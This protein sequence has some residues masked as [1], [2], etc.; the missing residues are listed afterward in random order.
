MKGGLRQSIF[1]PGRFICSNKGCRASAVQPGFFFFPFCAIRLSRRLAV[2][3]GLFTPSLGI[4]R[5]PAHTIAFRIDHGILAG[6]YHLPHWENSPEGLYQCLEATFAHTPP[7]AILVE[8]PS[9]YFAVQHFL[10]RRQMLVPE[11]VSLVCLS[12]HPA[13]E[14]CRPEVTHLNWGTAGL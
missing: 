9:L 11:D 6:R 4:S 7:T 12:P 1:S 5:P 10:S 13:F 8:E 2:G 14:W 3:R